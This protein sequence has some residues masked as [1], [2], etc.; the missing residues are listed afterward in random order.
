MFHFEFLELNQF[1][2]GSRV[3]FLEVANQR[4]GGVLFFLLTKT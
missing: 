1:L 2:L 3:G 4:L